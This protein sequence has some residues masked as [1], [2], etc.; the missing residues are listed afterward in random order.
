M[1]EVIPVLKYYT[2]QCYSKIFQFT[3][4]LS[5]FYFKAINF[6]VITNELL[7]NLNGDKDSIILMNIATS[8]YEHGRQSDQ[9]FQNT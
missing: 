2:S 9:I 6:I 3:Y 4:S 1:K 7:T 5:K 8:I